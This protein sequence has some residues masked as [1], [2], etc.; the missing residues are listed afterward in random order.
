MRDTY[1]EEVKTG[2]PFVVV[3]FSEQIQVLN[4]EGREMVTKRVLAL[5]TAEDLK[6]A[7]LM[8]LFQYSRHRKV[9]TSK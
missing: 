6:W 2:L 3:C 5:D 9:R 7:I 1:P 8:V 4:L